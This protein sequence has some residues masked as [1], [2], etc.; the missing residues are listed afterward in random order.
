MYT[1]DVRDIVYSTIQIPFK[2]V[3]RNQLVQLDSSPVKQLDLKKLQLK[4]H[5]MLCGLMIRATIRFWHMRLTI[6][7]SK[8]T[9]QSTKFVA[10]SMTSQT[11]RRHHDVIPHAVVDNFN[12]ILN[13]CDKS[14]KITTYS[15]WHV[16]FLCLFVDI[17]C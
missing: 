7:C 9:W 4:Y 6:L 2:F 15:W 3:Q 1:C 5:L 14:H 8:L 10:P 16:S 11:K 12:K 17:W 13:S